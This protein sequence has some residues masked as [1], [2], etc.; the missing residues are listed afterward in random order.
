MKDSIKILGIKINNVDIK[1]A[2][3]YAIDSVETDSQADMIVTPNSE[4][5]VMAQKDKHLAKIIND[6][7][8]SIPD[9]AGVL[10]ASRVVNTPLKGRVAGYDLMKQLLTVSAE[11]KYK[12]YLLGGEQKVIAEAKKKAEK[13]YPGIKI[14]G[15][16][17]GYLNKELKEKV[18]NEIN[19]LSPDILFVGMGVPLQEKFLY[20]NLS[21]LNVKLAITVGGAFDV[22]SGR[23]NRAPLWMQKIHLEWF[24]RLLQEPG[25][26]IRMTA[27]PYFAYLVFKEKLGGKR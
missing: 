2:V 23:A 7:Y 19:Q 26:F 6:S 16:H 22:L 21:N 4:M 10:L 17:H 20:K 13:L 24:F 3:D 25:R 11:K 1:N 5:I 12:V 27:L 8:L 14:C 15:Y 18:F 9:G